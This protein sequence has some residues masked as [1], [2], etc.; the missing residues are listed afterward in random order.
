VRAE[1]PRPDPEAVTGFVEHDLTAHLPA[2]LPGRNVL[3]LHAERLA[4]ESPRFLLL[5]VLE[6]DVRGDAAQYFTTPSPG[7]PNSPGAHA[8]AGDTEFSVDRGL[9]SEPFHVAMTTRTPAST[10]RYTLDGRLPTRSSGFVYTAPLRIESTTI[11][12]AAAFREGYLP[13]D[14]DTQTYLF[15]MGPEGVLRQPEEPLGYPRTWAGYPA[16]YGMDP[17]VVDDPLYAPA[18]EDDMRALPSLSIVTAPENLFGSTGIYDNPRSRGDSWERPASVELFSADGSEEL[19][20]PCG[21]RIQGG[22]GARPEY[23]KHSFRL[24]FRKT[25]GDGKLDQD[26]FGFQPQG[27]DTA[28]SFDKLSLRGGFNNTFPHWYDEQALR[29]QYVR[30]QWARDLQFEMG[31]KSTL[32]RYVHLYL[33]GMYWGLYNLGERPDDDFAAAYYGGE[34]EDYD[35]IKNKSATSGNGQAWTQLHSLLSQNVAAPEVYSEILQLVD[36]VNLIDYV[37]ENFYCGNTDWDNHNWVAIRRRE[38]G[39]R[40][41]FYAWDSEFGISL[42]P[43]AQPNEWAPILGIDRTALNNAQSPTRVFQRL[44]LN[45]EF[46]LLVADRIHRHFFHDGVLTPARVSEIWMR[47]AD[48]VHRA[49]VGES[50]RWGDFRRDVSASRDPPGVF[51]LFTRDEHYL[52]HQRFILE[53]YFPQR[54]EIVL[55]QF[56]RRGFYPDLEPPGVAPHGGDVEPGLQVLL[57]AASGAIHYTLDGSDPRLTGGDVSPTAFLGA[58]GTRVSLQRTTHLKARRLLDGEWSPLNEAHF[59]VDTGLRLTELM[60]HPPAPA[61]AEVVAGHDDA[62]DFEFLELL[63]TREDSLSLKG[64]RF[65]DG[66]QFIFADRT[67]HPGQR[68]VLVRDLE[69]FEARYGP[70]T[71]DTDIVAGVYQGQLSNS[72]ER[73]TVVSAFGEVLLDFEYDDAWHPETDGPGHSLVVENEDADPDTL[74]ERGSWRASA[75]EL[76]T[77]GA[78]DS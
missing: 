60:Y 70:E 63:N 55:D 36:P 44:R 6:A 14:V 19:Q 53:E 21:I 35:V 54:T 46:R 71:S 9:H 5:P 1:G 4:P 15:L 37:L 34:D 74:G 38:A 68:L 51:P 31:H 64:I 58:D 32:G 20:S 33:N 18:I 47:R 56:R 23:P 67:L 12:R 72:G 76:G 40:F 27:R 65:T 7:A 49:I 2:L 10:I 16:D 45:P 48:Q 24:I 41:L 73:V 3:A 59:T 13:T 11:L 17:E 29:A 50:A 61:P 78:A 62:D 25:Y 69:A 39:W 22:A 30:D 8:I 52:A 42:A 75:R 26:L 57:T 43:G 28:E 77:P 66:V